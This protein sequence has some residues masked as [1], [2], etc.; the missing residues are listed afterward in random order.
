MVDYRV[1]LTPKVVALFGELCFSLC[2]ELFEHLL[3][4]A[5]ERAADCIMCNS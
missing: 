2:L 4:T 3:I 5:D 1:P